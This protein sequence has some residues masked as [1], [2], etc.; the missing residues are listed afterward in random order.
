MWE[1]HGVG[2][3]AVMT[4]ET[5]VPAV[6]SRR[7]RWPV[8]LTACVAAVAVWTLLDPIGGVDLTVGK[9]GA[10]THIGAAAVVL[11]S[12]VAGLAAWGLLAIYERKLS[13][14]ARVWRITAAVVFVVSLLG[15]LGGTHGSDRIALA[16]L[17]LTVT[18]VLIPWLA[19]SASPRNSR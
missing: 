9:P 4:N 2:D 18:A 13:Q 16:S 7:P 17:H 6:T 12:L 14:P 3:A 8:V 5:A 19:R 11:A 15:P 1:A 10:T